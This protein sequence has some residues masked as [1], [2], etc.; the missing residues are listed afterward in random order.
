VRGATRDG[1]ITSGSG[2]SRLGRALRNPAKSDNSPI[3]SKDYP[4]LAPGS[5][6]MP[7]FTGNEA[8]GDRG[9]RFLSE[10]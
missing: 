3:R 9:D 8:A 2:L 10:G 5:R 6:L 4:R 1:S 7:E